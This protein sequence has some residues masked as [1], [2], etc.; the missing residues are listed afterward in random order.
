MTIAVADRKVYTLG[1]KVDLLDRCGD[2][3]VDLRIGR[4]EASKPVHEPLCAKVWRRAH[5]QS[6]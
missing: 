1:D 3:E 6:V 2:A 5:S 4:S